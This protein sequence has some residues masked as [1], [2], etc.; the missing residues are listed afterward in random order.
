MCPGNS[1]KSGSGS[2]LEWD[3]YEMYLW[4]HLAHSGVK[5]Q[6]YMCAY[7]YVTVVFGMRRGTICIL[8]RDAWHLKECMLDDV[9]PGSQLLT[10]FQ[11]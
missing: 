10:L 2:V 7:M 6:S 1:H 5:D 9:G 3:T 11:V 4:K 8:S